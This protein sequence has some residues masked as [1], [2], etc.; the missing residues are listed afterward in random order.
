MGWKESILQTEKDPDTGK[1]S[2]AAGEYVYCGLTAKFSFSR[3][4]EDLDRK[5]PQYEGRGSVSLLAPDDPHILLADRDRLEIIVEKK[6]RKVVKAAEAIGQ[7]VDQK[8]LREGIR[9]EL[10]IG[11]PI[12]RKATKDI[13]L[14]AFKAATVK[15]AV[16]KATEQLILENRQSLLARMDRQGTGTQVQTVMRLFF[17]FGSGF[18]CGERARKLLAKVCVALGEKRVEDLKKSDVK[19]I[20]ERFGVKGCKIVCRFLDECSGEYYGQNPFEKYPMESKAEKAAR[21]KERARKNAVKTR[22]IPLETEKK[23]F[24]MCRSDLRDGRCLV[25]ALAL[26]CYL[27]MEEMVSLKWSDVLFTNEGVFVRRFQRKRVGALH[28]YTCTLLPAAQDLVRERYEYLQ[29]QGYTDEELAD[30]TVL[31]FGQKTKRQLKVSEGTDYLRDSLHQA[32]VQ[33]SVLEEYQAQTAKRPG[34]AGLQLCHDH[35]RNV[36]RRAC[37]IPPDSPTEKFFRMIA[38]RRDSTNE[39]YRSFTGENGRRALAI[40]ARRDQRLLEPHKCEIQMDQAEDG[41]DRMSVLPG[42]PG[43]CLGV[44]LEVALKKG[45]CLLLE[46]EYGLH[47]EVGQL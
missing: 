42:L 18:Q 8:A 40:I 25:I 17:R 5:G 14:R 12:A 31:S 38:F 3:V 37:K 2:K 19:K 45:D 33:Y 11:R 23:L 35:V 44:V 30:M 32:G 9:K 36:Y 39:A 22:L 43:K 13:K 20:E 16:A 34:G 29:A 1:L 10:T 47:A 21:D 15:D 28:N 26:G 7:K 41:K 4:P 46:S 24:Q 6:V 27:S